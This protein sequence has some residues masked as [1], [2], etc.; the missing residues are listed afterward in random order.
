MCLRL[1]DGHI[2]Q[3]IFDVADVANVAIVVVA[4]QRVAK[5]KERVE[6]GTR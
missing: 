2:W 5:E 6:K 3:E 1:D 4:M